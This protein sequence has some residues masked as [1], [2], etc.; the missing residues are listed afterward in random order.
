VAWGL[1]LAGR[2][3]ADGALMEEALELALTAAVRPPFSTGVVD[4]GFCHG[5]AGVAHV[6]HRLYRESGRR[7]L[8]EAA[9]E[10]IA[11]TLA[12]R[13]RP[14]PLGG[15]Q[16]FMIDRWVDAPGLLMGTSGIA[17]VLGA[18]LGEIGAE[19]DAPLMLAS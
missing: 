9:R 15:Y 17:L 11:R 3:L 18:A 5:T 16:A 12:L 8:A 2:A 10:W 19:W 6:L 13:T 7:D 14:G 4:A 1:Y